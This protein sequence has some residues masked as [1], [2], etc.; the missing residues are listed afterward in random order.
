MKDKEILNSQLNDARNSLEIRQEEKDSLRL[1]L[2]DAEN[3]L[4]S[5][6]VEKYSLNSQLNDARDSQL[7]WGRRPSAYRE[8]RIEIHFIVYGG[9]VIWDDTVAR[10]LIGYARN[11][12]EWTMND[13]EMGSDPWYGVRKA[14]AI[15]YRYDGRGE[16]R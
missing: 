15:V 6:Q 13:T 7:S 14:G 10:R 11:Q 3:S 5:C 9:Q 8:G 4:Q 1:Q 2:K 12:Q 16:V